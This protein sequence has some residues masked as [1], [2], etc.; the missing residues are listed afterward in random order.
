MLFYGDRWR[1]RDPRQVFD[2]LDERL[3]AALAMPPGLPRHSALVAS[4]IAWGE[5][6]Q[7]VADAAAEASG[8]DRPSP[9]E[10]VLTARLVAIADAV[11]QSFDSLQWR[12]RGALPPLRR[13]PTSR[14]HPAAQPGGLSRITPS[15]PRPIASQRAKWPARL[16]A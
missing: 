5:L 7:G 12:S 11:R 1:E 10:T 6:L 3:A 13:P 14:T 2:D 8:L 4:L 16:P 9:E 15:I